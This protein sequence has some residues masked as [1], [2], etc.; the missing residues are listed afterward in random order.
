MKKFFVGCNLDFEAELERELKEVWPYLIELDG[1]IHCQ[2]LIILAQVPGGI[3]I[4]APL[5][6]GLQ[7]NFFLKCANRILLRIG[8]KKL[9]DFPAM[10]QWMQ[11][12]G[13]DPFLQGM[14]FAVSVTAK[15]SRLNNEKRIIEIM[16]ETIKIKDSAAQTLYVRMND[17]LCSV[18]LDTTGE[19][20]HKRTD[21]DVGKAPLRET[22]A[23][24]CLRKMIGSASPQEL[25]K[26]SLVDPMCGT[27]TLL[28]EARNL[29]QPKVCRQYAFQGFT[30]T[31][32]LLKSELLIK[33]YL[34]FPKLFKSCMG[35]DIDEQVLAIAKKT[36]TTQ[37][38]EMI[39]FNH[40]DLSKVSKDLD[41]G[42][43]W[44]I[45]N[46]PYGERVKS[47]LSAVEI[48]D[49]IIEKYRPQ[50]IALLMS[51]KQSKDLNRKAIEELGY[52]FAADTRFSNGGLAVCFV[53]AQVKEQKNTETEADS[54]TVSSSNY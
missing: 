9:R 29:Y 10:F 34:P 47:D 50:K 28:F 20:L 52:V 14:Q 13:K 5:H 45:S 44:V 19:L 36:A 46:I 31:P 41:L 39:S 33:N 42:N 6:L 27:G 54:A 21:K 40:Q 49:L 16:K 2:E 18:S 37:N 23:S 25:A 3:L 4:E 43:I 30:Q 8:E 7:L 22:I 35:Y 15:Q 26:L 17:D 12:I 48:A 51:D 24:F 1:K 11:K 53:Q 38:S 32:K